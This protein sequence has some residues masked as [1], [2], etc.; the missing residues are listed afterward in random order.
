MG[1]GTVAQAVGEKRMRNRENAG[2]TKTAR[3]QQAW[4]SFGTKD[5][6]LPTSAR[7]AAEWAVA[8]GILELPDID[9][10]DVLA[11]DMA[12]ALR[13]EYATDGRGRRYRV[14]H[15]VRVTK[16]G[17]QHTFWAMRCYAPHLHLEKAFAQRREQI[18]GDC[19]QLKTDV[20]VYNDM[21]KGKRHPIHVILDFGDDVTE[22]QIARVSK[23]S[24]A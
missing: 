12:Q 13:G 1:T 19:D 20:D 24:A 10:Y 4:H 8:E 11:G 3:L 22:R 7:R 2:P 21:N 5:D 9:P 14:N 6:H 17:V 15:A 16:S 23:G 18:V